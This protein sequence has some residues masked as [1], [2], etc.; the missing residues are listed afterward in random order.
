MHVCVH[1]CDDDIRVCVLVF[2][3]ICAADGVVAVDV[4]GVA[5][6][7]LEQGTAAQTNAGGSRQDGQ[8]IS[9]WHGD[10]CLAFA[11]QMGVAGPGDPSSKPLSLLYLLIIK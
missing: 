5:P 2:L 6:R 1:F 8:G 10:G 4:L 11:R 3:Y 9:S 7:V